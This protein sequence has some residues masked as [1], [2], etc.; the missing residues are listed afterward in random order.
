MT[1][2]FFIVMLSVAMMAIQVVSSTLSLKIKRLLGVNLPYRYSALSNIYF[3]TKWLNLGVDATILLSI[4]LL[5]VTTFFKIHRFIAELFGCPYCIGFWI[6]LAVNYYYFNFALITS[7]LYA[8][9][10]LVFVAILDKI[11]SQ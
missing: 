7:L 4:P 11:M 5:L 8:P 10:A 6:S 2:E 3:Y 9:L 1:I